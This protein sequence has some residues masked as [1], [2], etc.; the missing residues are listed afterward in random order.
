MAIRCAALVGGLALST[1]VCGLTPAHGHEGNAEIFARLADEVEGVVSAGDSGEYASC[2]QVDSLFDVMTSKV[3]E[4][5]F[6][7]DELSRADCRKNFAR[8]K[9]LAPRAMKSARLEIEAS[10]EAEYSV[11]RKRLVL[12]LQA[13]TAHQC[14][15]IGDHF[16]GREPTKASER[17][18]GEFVAERLEGF[19]HRV[20]LPMTPEEARNSPLRSN[21]SD[22]KARVRFLVKKFGTKPLRHNP[23]IFQA[24]DPPRGKYA[25]VQLVGVEVT[26]GN[27]EVVMA[28]GEFAPR[29]A[30]Q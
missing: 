8:V 19:L 12:T 7:G 2:K 26:D 16:F 14:G 18:M 30:D 29:D 21:A 15:G 11:K 25:V 13:K 4:Y 23:V 9:S 5:C 27:G 3:S 24:M 28:T 22:T 17:I 6:G 10:A 1:A 20:E